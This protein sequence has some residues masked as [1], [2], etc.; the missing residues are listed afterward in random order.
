[1]THAARRQ[2]LP[3]LFAP[4]PPAARCTLEFFTA[5]IRNPG[6]PGKRMP[7]RWE[8]IPL[9][10]FGAIKPVHVAANVEAAA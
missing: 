7:G 9:R 5:N 6:H 3:T 10:E 4:A 1:M 8:S 2:G